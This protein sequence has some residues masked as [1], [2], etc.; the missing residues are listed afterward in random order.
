MSRCE[1]K[2]DGKQKLLSLYFIYLSC[3]TTTTSKVKKMNEKEKKKL[4]GT[5][6]QHQKQHH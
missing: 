1:E 5:V 2:K 6:N 4:H 3:T